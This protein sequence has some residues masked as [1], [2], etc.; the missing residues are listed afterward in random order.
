MHDHCLIRLTC[1]RRREG[2]ALAPLLRRYDPGQ[3]IITPAFASVARALLRML[4]LL[5][6]EVGLAAGQLPVIIAADLQ[7]PERE[8]DASMTQGLGSLHRMFSRIVAMVGSMREGRA[9]EGAGS[10]HEER[11]SLL[12]CA[13]SLGALKSLQRL[14][15]AGEALAH[16]PHI[17]S[18]R[19][20]PLA[21][22]ACAM[23][24]ENIA[25]GVAECCVR[26]A[27]R[28]GADA[29]EQVQ[30]NQWFKS[31]LAAAVERPNLAAGGPPTAEHVRALFSTS[32]LGAAADA[33]TV[34][35]DSRPEAL[36]WF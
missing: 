8:H 6:E 1:L 33:H 15:S 3:A 21:P 22:H 14:L 5:L 25:P 10:R 19:P 12:T 32:F 34:G 28:A 11:L 9:R 18:C 24:W 27:G 35:L 30:C 16:C 20:G 36:K 23:T 17:C 29:A 31:A 13:A 26:R 2:V 7:P 4:P